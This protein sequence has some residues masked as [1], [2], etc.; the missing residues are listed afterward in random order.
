MQKSTG[1][2]GG[3]GENGYIESQ[4]RA[5]A[6]VYV[7]GTEKKGDAEECARIYATWKRNN[8]YEWAV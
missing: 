6:H 7:G 2:P 8:A 1:V 3:E 4:K 5:R